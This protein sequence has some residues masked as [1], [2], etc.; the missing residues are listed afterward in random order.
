[1]A[2]ALL[3]AALGS[4]GAILGA[5]C[6]LALQIRPRMLLAVLVSFA[7]GTLLASAF[8]G[9][10][11]EALDLRSGLDV[12]ATILVAILAFFLLEKLLLWRH[13]HALDP[14]RHAA[15]GE[16]I[17]VGDFFHNLVDG[18]I[19]GGA[20]AT[21][22]ALGI[23]T[24]IA[25]IAHE[26]P[27]EVGDFAILLDSGFSRSR[28]FTYNVLSASSTIP[29]AAIA[30]LALEDIEFALPFI[31]AIAAASFIYIALADLVPRLHERTAIR[32][33]PAQMLPILAGV[34]IIVLVKALT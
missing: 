8:L 16:L 12:P 27:Q 1:M 2:L 19:I 7:T 29:A 4:I 13:S 31:L 3:F 20:F 14:E 33:L 9:L 32:D 18:A 10:L 23:T 15:S 30:Y 21:D 11:P 28:A 24:S 26:V 6:V 17:L 5:S 25:V 34:G 22:P